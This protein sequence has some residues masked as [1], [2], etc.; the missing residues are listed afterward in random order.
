M[1][2]DPAQR[3]KS[4]FLYRCMRSSPGIIVKSTG[5]SPVGT[6][7]EVSVAW[8]SYAQVKKHVSRALELE[9]ETDI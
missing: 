1:A 2:A 4:L 9:H 3:A 6:P 5:D 7:E 8:L